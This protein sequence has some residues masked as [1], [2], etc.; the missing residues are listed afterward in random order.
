[1]TELTPQTQHAARN[2]WLAARAVQDAVDLFCDVAEE[3]PVATR[4]RI[5]Q[6]FEVLLRLLNIACSQVQ[7]HE[8]D[9]EPLEEPEPVV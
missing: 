8:Q 7:R 9:E 5:R 6:A 3:I 4:N 2:I 1:M